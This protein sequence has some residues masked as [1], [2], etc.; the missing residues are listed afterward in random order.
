MKGRDLFIVI[1][2]SLTIQLGHA[3]CPLLTRPELIKLRKMSTKQRKPF[4]VERQSKSIKT[5]PGTEKD[6]AV[7]TFGR[8]KE[9]LNDRQWYWSEVITYRECDRVLTYSTSDE[10]HFKEVMTRILQDYSTIGTRTYGGLT[11]TMYENE[12]GK[13]IEINHHPNE[14]GIVFWMTNMF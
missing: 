4:L 11:Y 10:G 13:L 6:C 2:I 14:E 1:V 7:Y 3:Q 9:F 8:C 12:D 5:V